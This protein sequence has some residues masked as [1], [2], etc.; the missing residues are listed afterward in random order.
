[1]VRVCQD[2]FPETDG[3]Y[4]DDLL[5]SNLDALL[6]NAGKKDDWDFVILIS[7][8]GMVRQGKSLLGIQIA[9]YWKH[10]LKELHGVEIPFSI[11]DNIVFK[12]TELIEKGNYLGKNFPQSILIFDEAGAD[13]ESTKVLRGSTQ[14]VKDF[15]RECGQ[16][17]LLTILVIPEYF[18]LPK[19][20]ALS[21]SDLLIDVYSN[22]NKDGKF[23]R[24]FANFYSRPNK[25]M[26][27]LNGKKDLNY[28]AYKYD[29]HFRFYK[30]YPIDEQEYRNAKMVALQ[31]REPN[32]K[33]DKYKKQR[34]ILLDL[35][36]ERGLSHKQISDLLRKRG[37]SITHQSI[38]DAIQLAP[39]ENTTNN[40]YEKKDEEEEEEEEVE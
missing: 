18:D 5:K 19:G 1:M 9:S 20:I 26:L 14:A 25:K 10:Q 23:E 30:F 35:L 13:L 36:H 7:G 6:K 21:R 38:S 16:Y 32:A 12:G 39:R 17:N 31:S 33:E 24:G 28:R 15:F 27:Y 11:K 3:F 37:V 2:V 29:F 4:M 22:P 8:G 40:L 34:D